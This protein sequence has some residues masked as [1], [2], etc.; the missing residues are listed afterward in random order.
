ALSS[1][2]HQGSQAYLGIFGDHAQVAVQ[3][4]VVEDMPFAYQR[5]IFLKDVF[6]AR[7]VARLAFELERVIDQVRV[8]A[9][10]GF[11]ET[12]IFVSGAKQAFYTSVNLYACSHLCT[13]GFCEESAQSRLGGRELKHLKSLYRRGQAK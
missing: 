1:T 11:D 6:G 4:A 2:V 5:N 3:I 10:A 7:D 9:E 8:N 12:D 13:E